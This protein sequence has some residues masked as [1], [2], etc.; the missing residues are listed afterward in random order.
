MALIRASLMAC[1]T[2]K[3]QPN[4]IDNGL[5]DFDGLKIGIYNSLLGFNGTED[6]ING[7]LT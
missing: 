2:W 3:V 6:G 4:G 5:L 1:W 7:W